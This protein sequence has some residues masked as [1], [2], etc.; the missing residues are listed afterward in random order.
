MV[1]KAMKAV[2]DNGD[3]RL[4]DLSSEVRSLKTLVANRVSGGASST[5]GPAPRPLASPAC[6]GGQSFRP[7]SAQSVNGSRPQSP[8]VQADGPQSPTT[9]NTSGVPESGSGSSQ[10]GRFSSS[11]SGIPAWQMAASKNQGDSGIPAWQLAD[12]KRRG[13]SQDQKATGDAGDAANASGAPAE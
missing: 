7:S 4:R 8:S 3:A 6:N 10:Y 11:K 1:P 9:A 12:A 5:S 2:E 13:D